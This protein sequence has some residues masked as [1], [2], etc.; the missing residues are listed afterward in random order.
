M[1]LRRSLFPSPV[2]G[3]KGEGR[4][5]DA[6]QSSPGVESVVASLGSKLS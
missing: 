4:E 2:G 5:L 3:D 1:F 6:D